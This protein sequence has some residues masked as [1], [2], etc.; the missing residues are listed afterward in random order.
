MF[1]VEISEAARA[2]ASAKTLLITAGAGMG[3]D[4]A[5]VELSMVWRT[6]N[7]RGPSLVVDEESRAAWVGSSS[8]LVS[9]GGR[10][11]NQAINTTA[12]RVR[13]MAQR[14]RFESHNVSQRP[15]PRAKC[16]Y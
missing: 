3:V 5:S 16:R 4:L 1:R 14:R 2:L 13:P 8:W 10:V 12:M 6:A 9:A 7:W 11:A 15:I